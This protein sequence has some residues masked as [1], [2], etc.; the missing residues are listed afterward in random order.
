MPPHLSTTAEVVQRTVWLENCR[1][2]LHCQYPTLEL[3]ALCKVLQ[4][5]GLPVSGQE[6]GARDCMEC[7]QVRGMPVVMGQVRGRGDWVHM[8]LLS[9]GVDAG[10]IGEGG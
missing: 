1:F 6:V 3:Y 7:L 9:V 4:R 5:W 10:V 2:S 8:L